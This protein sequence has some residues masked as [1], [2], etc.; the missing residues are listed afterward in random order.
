MHD[1]PMLSADERGR[2]ARHQKFFPKL[3]LSDRFA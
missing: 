3:L 1:Q 2:Y